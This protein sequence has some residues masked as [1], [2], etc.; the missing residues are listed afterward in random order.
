MYTIASLITLIYFVVTAIFLLPDAYMWLIFVIF[1]ISQTTVYWTFKWF[2]PKHLS[3]LDVASTH[4]FIS[5]GIGALLGY[6]LAFNAHSPVPNE[7]RWT[8]V[9]LLSIIG[10][11]V[12]P[13]LWSK[14]VKQ[15]SPDKPSQ[16]P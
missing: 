15:P 5:S 10:S 11:S 13:R 1:I 4:R 14:Q 2:F 12:I 16:R 7:W 8:A 3:A 6:L 9:A